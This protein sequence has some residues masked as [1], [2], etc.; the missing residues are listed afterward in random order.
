ML[1]TFATGRWCGFVFVQ[2]QT[3]AEQAGQIKEMTWDVVWLRDR[4]VVGRIAC[5]DLHGGDDS[6]ILHSF[7]DRPVASMVLVR[8]GRSCR[9]HEMGAVLELGGGGLRPDEALEHGLVRRAPALDDRVELLELGLQHEQAPR[10]AA[11][12]KLQ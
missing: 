3:T 6:A 5:T 9:Q 2:A 1:S 8:K 7:V 4:T 10:R 12:A 11:R